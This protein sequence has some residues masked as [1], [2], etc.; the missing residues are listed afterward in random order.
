MSQETQPQQTTTAQPSTLAPD[1]SEPTETEL[2]C[3]VGGADGP[4]G[5]TDGT[6]R[7]SV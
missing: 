3:V 4:G 1:P 6:G 7:S 2:A 5:P